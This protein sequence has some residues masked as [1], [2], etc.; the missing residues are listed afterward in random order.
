[1]GAFLPDYN[2]PIV[3]ILLLLGII[4]AISLL[5][6]GFTIW[7]QEVKNKEMLEFLK[8]F[9]SSEC[10]LDTEN[11]P[12]DESM[13][14]PLFMLALSFEKSGDYSRAVNL[15]LFLLKH[16][17]E[18]SILSHL[19]KAYYRAG[20]LKRAIDI[21]KEILYQ[22]PRDIEVL[23]NL[24]FISEQLRDYSRASEA[25]DILE[26]LGED[27]SKYRS[28]LELQVILK[29]G[30][31]RSDKF[32]KIAEGI[33]GSPYRAVM[34]RE[35]FMLNAKD[36]W[37][38]YCDSEFEN[39]VD[40]LWKLDIVQLNL[41]I[42]SR[43]NSLKKLYWTKGLAQNSYSKAESIFALDLLASAKESGYTLADLSFKYSCT[44]CKSSFPLMAY[45]CPNCHEVYSFKVEVLVEKK[46]EKSSY[47][48]L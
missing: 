6:Y 37:E 46:Q 36:A 13:K 27:V 42:I 47:S 30:I 33:D 35:L 38:Y 40:I 4:F 43:N 41:D 26:N 5:S 15:Y 20:F 16:T 2:D 21:Y 31:K 9:E 17:K 19:A 39:L 44:S 8:N 1:M 3:S 48:L 11:M 34:L 18:N 29:S 10:T 25:L 14:K 24:E 22:T 45:R 32:K 23:Y 7:R 12:F 28:H